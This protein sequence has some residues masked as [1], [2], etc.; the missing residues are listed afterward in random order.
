MP[1]QLLGE[2]APAAAD[3]QHALAAAQLE[4]RRGAIELGLLRPLER[5]AVV[6]KRRRI[7]HRLVEPGA[8]EFVAEIVVRRD[9][10]LAAAPRVVAQP[11]RQSIAHKAEPAD[12]RRRGQSGF[13]LHV[14][15]EHL[16]ELGRRPVAVEITVGKAVIAVEQHAAQ[17]A[18]AMR[19]HD[20][21]RPRK[22]AVAFDDFTVRQR[23]VQSPGRHCRDRAVDDAAEHSPAAA[24]L[25]RGVRSKTM[26]RR[27]SRRLAFGIHDG[28]RRGGRRGPRPQLQSFEQ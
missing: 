19:R 24:P 22:S 25:R 27:T 9:I 8:E 7:I 4:Q 20:R 17:T 28:Y 1:N 5:V 12:G 10:A 16:A 14:E 23:E 11:V 15:F 2:R 6:V 3:L 26:G 13:V 18:P 21:I